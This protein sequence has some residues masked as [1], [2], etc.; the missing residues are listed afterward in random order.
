MN[1]TMTHKWPLAALAV[2]CALAVRDVVSHARL[3][4]RRRLASEQVQEWENE[5]G[6]VAPSRDA[7]TSGSH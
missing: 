1:A 7:T 3:R 2:T 5:G 4:E 6:A